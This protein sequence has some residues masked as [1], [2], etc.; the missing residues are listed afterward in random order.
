MPTDTPLPQQTVNELKK[1]LN[2]EVL[3]HWNELARLSGEVA[4]SLAQME[5]IIAVMDEVFGRVDGDPVLDS[6][7]SDSPVRVNVKPIN[8]EDLG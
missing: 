5:V 1:T 6:P 4:G 8:P 7:V 2:K 3:L